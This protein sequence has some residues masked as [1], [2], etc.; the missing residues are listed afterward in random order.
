MQRDLSLTQRS[1]GWL[2]LA[3]LLSACGDSSG[4][5][6]SSGLVRLITS[7][8]GTALDPDG[9]TITM[10]GGAGRS[11]KLNDTT[12]I[13]LPAGNHTLL[14]TGLSTNWSVSGRNP[15]SVLIKARHKL[16]LAFHVTCN[17]GTVLVSTL[18]TGTGLDPDGY[19]IVIDSGTGRSIDVNGTLAIELPPGSYDLRLNGLAPNCRVN[20]LNPHSVTITSQHDVPLSFDVLCDVG[21]GGVVITVANPGLPNYRPLTATLTDSQGHAEVISPGPL[22]G[23]PIGP[24]ALELTSSSPYFY[25]ECNIASPNPQTVN[26]TSGEF[27]TVTFTVRCNY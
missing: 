17:G 13:G 15:Q 25:L 11:V 3:V 18:T 4:P 9:Y 27:A 16:P 7:T 1:R 2:L 8:T 10:D 26:I 5:Q 23:L 19:T 24:Y 14:L 12:V 6:N 21:L 20:G 22:T